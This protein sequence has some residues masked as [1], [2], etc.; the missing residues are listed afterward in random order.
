MARYR[1]LETRI[2]DEKETGRY[3]V[4]TRGQDRPWWRFWG[5]RTYDW[6]PLQARSSWWR[7]PFVPS[8]PTREMA[9]RAAAIMVQKSEGPPAG[10]V[11]IRRVS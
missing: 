3:T 10:G 1:C 7:R 5:W 8:F 9:Q 11:K 6:K 4:Q 2:R